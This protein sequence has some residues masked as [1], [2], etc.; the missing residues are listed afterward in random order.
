M[1]I[2]IDNNALTP[3]QGAVIKVIGVG[4]AGGN[5]VNT[6]ID[7]GL[8]GVEFIAANTDIQ[9]LNVNKADVHV[10]IG[11]KE[12]EGLGAGADP[13][14]GETSVLEDSDLIKEAIGKPHMV[15]VTAGMG[16]GTGTG[17]APVVAKMAM[18]TNA[19]TVGIV[20]KPF[21]FEGNRRMKSAEEG[22]AKLRNNVDTLIVI[23]NQ[24]LM[25]INK[26]SLTLQNAFTMADN[27]LLQATKGISDIIKGTGLIN[28]DF[29]DVKSIMTTSGDAI[30][31][32]GEASGEGRATQA[33][34]SAISSPLLE[35]Y[36]LQGAKGILINITASSNILMSE[37]DEATEYIRA[38]T[39]TDDANVIF[40]V[41]LDESLEEKIQITVI[42]TGFNK[43]EEIVDEIPSD[44]NTQHFD[45]V[46]VQQPKRE[47]IV[48]K[49]HG[50]SVNPN[51]DSRMGGI[52]A[53][54]EEKG[55][56]SFNPETYRTGINAV[57]NLGTD[58]G[59][60]SQPTFLRRKYN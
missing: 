19:L 60:L 59:N 24:K 16:G 2:T 44:V 40:G 9:A 35:E 11:K 56:N 51:H 7:S 28:V 13:S 58:K 37:I 5:A 17:A 6:M 53:K 14:V 45:D 21:K 23:P 22:I 43:E 48:H 33:A 27:V 39:Q 25:E 52:S 18:E 10:Q 3:S 46:P 34:D 29:A 50:D 12:T 41:V 20:T 49:L 36:S 31:G 8:S 32:I 26:G 42:A 30:M 54:Y 4:G 15:F 55:E 47:R 1:A 38:K 57:P